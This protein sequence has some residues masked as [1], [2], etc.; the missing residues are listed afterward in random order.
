MSFICSKS[1]ILMQFCQE[2]R[3]VLVLGLICYRNARWLDSHFRSFGC[4]CA[5]LQELKTAGVRI[6]CPLAPLKRVECQPPNSR[7]DAN[8]LG[9]RASRCSAPRPQVLPCQQVEEFINQ[10]KNGGQVIFLLL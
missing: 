7:Q 5:H 8:E 1:H 3:P 4:Q 2:C 9:E 10:M 6:F